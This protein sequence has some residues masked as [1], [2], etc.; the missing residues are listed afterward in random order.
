MP[1]ID[2][3][4]TEADI[5]TDVVA[6]NQPGFSAE[7]ARA[8]LDLGFNDAARQKMGRLAAKNNQ[9]TLTEAERREM[10]NYVRVGTFLDLLQA[11]ARVSLQETNPR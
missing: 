1:Q 4:A 8:I 11:K 2:S 3:A 5:L 7:T 10:E 6:P 9:G